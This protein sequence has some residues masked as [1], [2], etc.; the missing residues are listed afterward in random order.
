VPAGALA[1]TRPEIVFVEG[2]AERKRARMQA[3]KEGNVAKAGNGART[4]N[5]T[6]AHARPNFPQPKKKNASTPKKK[7]APKGKPARKRG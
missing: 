4:S 5:G 7:A 6:S 2:W 3:A 1:V